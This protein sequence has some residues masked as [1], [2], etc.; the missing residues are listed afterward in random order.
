[1]R[2]QKLLAVMLTSVFIMVMMGTQAGWTQEA[3]VVDVN[4]V[5]KR[6]EA[7]EKEMQELKA[8]LAQQQAA[9]SPG[10]S[11]EQIKFDGKAYISYSV[12]TDGAD[13]SDN[14]FTVDR[15]YFSA[16]K[17]LGDGVSVKMTTDVASKVESSKTKFNI[18]LKN[19]YAQFD[20]VVPGA[21]LLFGQQGG[22]WTSNEESAWK[23]RATRKV[24][25]D[26]RGL[27]NS[28]DFGL[29]LKGKFSGVDGD[30][31]ILASNGEGYGSAEE[32]T[33]KNGKDLTARVSVRLGKNAPKLSLYGDLGS[34][35][36]AK[37]NRA[38]IMLDQQYN[39]FSWGASYIYAKDA[40]TKK[41]GLSLFSNYDFDGTPWSVLGRYDRYDPNTSASS[42]LRTLLLG[43]F[44]YK[45]NKSSKFIFTYSVDRD[46]ANKGVAGAD[47]NDS[48]MKVTLEVKY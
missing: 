26:D 30:Y 17:N 16:G 39:A 43:G 31:Q 18:F 15:W 13:K 25:A 11:G 34:A 2:I 42:D 40:A 21:S 41:D 8:L 33:N 3:G 37:S 28:A 38:A 23:Y 19:A 44:A 7:L 12:D 47:V 35:A 36:T 27:L 20:N 24:L 46:S 10:T 48:M 1:M 45:V 6:M 14:E 4:A 9:V 32:A 22:T 29:G 5:M